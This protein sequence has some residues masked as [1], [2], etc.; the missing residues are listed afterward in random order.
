MVN[1]KKEKF[2]KKEYKVTLEKNKSKKKASLLFRPICDSV[3]L[4]IIYNDTLHLKCHALSLN[5]E[6][7]V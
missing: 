7:I 3:F 4:N 1:S 6:T 5:K 2:N